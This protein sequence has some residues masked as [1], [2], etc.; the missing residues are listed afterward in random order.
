VL[1]NGNTAGSI[2]GGCLEQ[3]II[4][5]AQSVMAAGVP[6]VLSYDT[7]TEEDLVFGVGLGCKGVVRI[8]VEPLRAEDAN[9]GGGAALLQFVEELLEKRRSGL[10]ATVFGLAGEPVAKIG[11]RMMITEEGR[12]IDPF[13]NAALSKSITQNA[14]EI[15]TRRR[16]RTLQLEV[17]G[18]RVDILMELIESPIP[19]VIF[20][21]GFD[22]VPLVR[23]AK[24]IGFHVTV[25]DARSA[26]ATRV[27]FPEA[28]RALVVQPATVREAIAL[29]ERTAAV[30]MSHN[31]V[32][33]RS[34]LNAL[35]PIPLRYLGM[36]GPK[37]RAEKMFQESLEEG[38]QFD[39]EQK[40][41]LHNPIGLD[42]GAE[43]P[44]EIAL[45]VL[46]EIQAVT[47]GY[48]GGMLCE[49]QSSIHTA[50]TGQQRFDRIVAGSPVSR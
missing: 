29:P 25:A 6:R 20:G 5:H 23:L 15:L 7:S 22:A 28:D 2:S 18:G 12:I 19:L 4:A 3:D 10:V 49:K 50:R 34:F 43:S 35:M 27:R 36:M 33:D 45:S 9:I 41:R 32:L 44:E 42:I 46:A 16:S 38:L 14:P 1:P 13:E 8:L 26:Y 30:I 11:S 47:A 24:E 48:A 39:P 21:A 40:L 37:K 17:N 31:Y